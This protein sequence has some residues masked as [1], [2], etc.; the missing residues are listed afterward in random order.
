MRTINPDISFFD[1]ILGGGVQSAPYTQGSSYTQGYLHFIDWALTI[2]AS[3]P[4]ILLL[5]ATRCAGKNR[6]S[7]QRK[8]P[9]ETVNYELIKWEV[10]PLPSSR[11]YRLVVDQRTFNPYVM[12]SNPI[13]S[14]NTKR[15]AGVVARDN[16]MLAYYPMWKR[17]RLV[18][19]QH[20]TL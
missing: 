9:H 20:A 10:Q 8:T 3:K 11:I 13:R 14:I 7:L 19:L 6:T 17:K 2:Y 4:Y 5:A 1:T 12:G 18:R 15:Q 16:V